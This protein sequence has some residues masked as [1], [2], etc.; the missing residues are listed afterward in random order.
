MFVPFFLF[1]QCFAQKLCPHLTNC[2][3]D[4]ISGC[5]TWMIIKEVGIN[6]YKAAVTF[7]KLLLTDAPFPPTNTQLSLKPSELTL[8]LPSS[9]ISFLASSFN[10]LKQVVRCEPSLQQKRRIYV[11]FPDS[12]FKIN[13]SPSA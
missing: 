6:Q 12:V 13:I 9:A 8:E 3:F 2:A 10:L 1:S 11:M 4:Y 5:T 7:S